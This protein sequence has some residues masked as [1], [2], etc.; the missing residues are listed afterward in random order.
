M[1]S[2]MKVSQ[3]YE[4]GAAL[5]VFQIAGNIFLTYECRRDEVLTRSIFPKIS[6]FPL[7]LTVV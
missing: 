5:A 4:I 6:T 3:C 2:Q 1:S 7:Y